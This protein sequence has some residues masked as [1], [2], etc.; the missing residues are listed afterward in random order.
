[1]RTSWR[2]WGEASEVRARKGPWVLK[3]TEESWDLQVDR[4]SLAPL[5]PVATDSTTVIIWRSHQQYDVKIQCL[6]HTEC[7]IL[8]SYATEF[9]KNKASVIQKFVIDGVIIEL[10]WKM[11]YSQS[12]SLAVTSWLVP[13]GAA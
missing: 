12:S 7:V 9:Y 4:E 5:V 11:F 13:G 6:N 3:V 1:M 2:G 10:A 8:K